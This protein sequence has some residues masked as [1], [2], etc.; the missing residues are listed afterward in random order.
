M[1]K[2]CDDVL[3]DRQLDKQQT[4]PGADSCAKWSFPQSY[5]LFA[6]DL[7]MA[8]PVKAVVPR[9]NAAR[10][11][12]FCIFVSATPLLCCLAKKENRA[13]AS[14]GYGSTRA[15]ERT[16]WSP[17][18]FVG[19]RAEE[20]PVNSCEWSVGCRGTRPRQ[21]DSVKARGRITK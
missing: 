13:V 14:R 10:L 2:R 4:G 1:L 17:G 20:A 16:G 15:V 12:A 5:G 11:P 19:I 8:G 9:G 7:W 6:E 18:D 3:L 21:L